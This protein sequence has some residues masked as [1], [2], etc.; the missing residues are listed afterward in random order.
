MAM[1]LCQAFQTG[2]SLRVCFELGVPFDVRTFIERCTGILV[3]GHTALLTEE[4]TRPLF[5]SIAGLRPDLQSRIAEQGVRVETV[6]YHILRGTWS[7]CQVSALLNRGVP[8][9]WIF[10]KTPHPIWNPAAYAHLANHLR[11]VLLEEYARK[12]LEDRQFGE[13]TSKRIAVVEEPP[14]PSYYFCEQPLQIKSVNGTVQIAPCGRFL[15]LPVLLPTPNGFAKSI[16]EALSRA[17]TLLDCGTTL[18][19]LPMDI[20]Y[21]SEAAVGECVEKLRMTKANWLIVGQTM[22]QLSSETEQ[23]LAIATAQIDENEV[24]AANVDKHTD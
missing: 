18:I 21:A 14:Q 2:N 23:K 7:S 20:H 8:L 3:S 17:A 16:R 13:T 12:Q 4:I 9:S 24:D 1:L 6:C 5:I 22:A 19:V 15:L 11:A 10:H